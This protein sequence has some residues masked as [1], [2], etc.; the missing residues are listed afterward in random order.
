[1]AILKPRNLSVKTAQII[2]SQAFQSDPIPLSLQNSAPATGLYSQMLPLS[3]YSIN[4]P[5]AQS[6][7][8]VLD[9]HPIQRDIGERL[10][11]SQGFCE[12]I[13]YGGKEA[14]L[15]AL[16]HQPKVFV[17]HRGD[18]P[19][20]LGIGFAAQ[21]VDGVAHL[22]LGKARGQY[23]H[24]VAPRK[25]ARKLVLTRLENW[26]LRMTYEAFALGVRRRRL[27]SDFFL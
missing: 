26:V 11:V 6:L 13:V 20:H 24:V 5:L 12:L 3:V 25:K 1:M 16:G 27:Y 23:P 15:T 19:R 14:I 9:T 22:G 2:P 17:E 21:K 18:L 8:H 4:L 7:P 10:F